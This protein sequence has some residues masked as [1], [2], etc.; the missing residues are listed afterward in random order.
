VM[1]NFLNNDRV[2]AVQLGGAL[3]VIAAILCLA[4]VKEGKK[5]D[6]EDTIRLEME[7]QRS[8]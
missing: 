3:F 1:T 5:P 4:L 7:E 6:E 8:I 2:L